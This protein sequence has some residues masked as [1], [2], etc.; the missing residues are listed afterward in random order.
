[1]RIPY[2]KKFSFSGL[3]EVSYNDYLF[4]IP[5]S[6]K[7]TEYHT[8]F[9]QQTYGIGVGGFI[10][11]PRLAVFTANLKFRDSRQ[12][13]GVGG[14]VNSQVYG[15]N[16]LLTFL[17]YRPVSFDILGGYTHDTINP[18]GNF[19]N[20]QWAVTQNL[21]DLYYGARLKIRK[22]SWPIIRL[23]YEHRS[24]DLFNPGQG[25]GTIAT[26]E[27]TLDIR[28]SFRFLRTIYLG[29]FRYTDFSSPAVS[30]KSKEV[31]LNLRSNITRGVTWQNT[32]N[33]SDIDF[34]KLLS[35]GSNLN[36][37]RT[38]IFNQFY[39]YQFYRSENHFA[40]NETQGIAAKDIKQT[41][42]SLTGSW[43]YRFINGPVTS[44]SLNY[45]TEAD[46]NEKAK[47][48]GINFSVSYGRP[49]LGLSFSPRYRLLLRKDELRGE[50]LENNLELNLVTKNVSWGTAYSNYSLT[51]S[52]E[53]AKFRQVTTDASATDEEAVMKETKIDSII[54]LLR[55]GLRGRA[56][57][58]RLSRAVWNIEAQVFISDATITRPIPASAL[59]E[60]ADQTS[61]TET[62]KRNVRR[63]SLLG[64][65]AYPTGWAS[66]FFSTGYSIGESNGRSLGR[67][68]YEERIQYPIRR[69]LIVLARWKQLWE[70]I[71]DTPSR[72]VDEYNLTAEYRI[73]RTTL[74]AEGSVLRSTTNSIDIYVRR[75]FLKLRRTI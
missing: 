22:R 61:Q 75:F 68:F 64:N 53:K 73:G 66:I 4:Q 5:S 70:N 51:V 44:L 47:F 32:F 72:R 41:I 49:L 3:I 28:G 6:G 15:G 26:D 37:R 11:H 24:S 54:H 74:S 38:E 71:Q 21:N 34:S 31:Q 65:L 7:N 25:Y 17:P 45:G 39:A 62:I 42:N 35:V 58:K 14:K 63:Y 59:D 10:Y 30:Y 36:I 18:I 12:L 50:L 48:Y 43:T 67:F 1:M 19:I 46:N 13:A 29:L 8:S 55:A 40:G 27:V 60:E 57:G 52:K 16:F 69:N 2:P 33:Y 9:I 23:E 56:P 20:S